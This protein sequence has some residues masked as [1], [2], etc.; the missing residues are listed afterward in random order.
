MTIAATFA[1]LISPAPAR[2]PKTPAITFVVGGRRIT[3][4]HQLN[5][6]AAN[7]EIDP[8]RLDELKRELRRAKARARYQR[9]KADPVKRAKR[10]AYYE[11]NREYLLAWKREYEK[12]HRAQ[13][14][15]VKTAWMRR[16]Y[17][18]D[19]SKHLEACKRYY[20]LHRE[21]VLARHKAKR[22]AARSASDQRAA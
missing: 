15:K 7:D 17:R 12:T 10:E 19:P 14:Q 9:D 4:A 8:E 3:D 11:A 6:A 16:K 13:I 20:Q 1:H 2:L 21:E 5:A 22:D 18:E